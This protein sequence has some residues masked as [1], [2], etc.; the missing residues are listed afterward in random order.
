MTPA[1]TL[2]ELLAG[3]Q[4]SA[5]FW[6]VHLD[7]NPALL[8]LPCS[9]GGAADVQAFVR[10][11]FAAELIWAQRV[12]GL[13]EISRESI[14]AGPLDTLFGLH[15][16]AVR[17][18]RALIDDQARNWDETLTLGFSWLPP[19][20]RTGSKR[21]LAAHALFHSQR[22]WAQLATLVRAAE[23]PS[24]FKGDLLFSQALE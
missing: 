1:V 11:I 14:P 7:A 15:L 12:A 6:K 8:E 3:S 5:D 18:F 2:E 19:H 24:G 22:H 17:V 10:H 9:I 23:F 13:P 21:K 20:A 16:E 4:E